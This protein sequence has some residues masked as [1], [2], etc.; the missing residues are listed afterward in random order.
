VEGPLDALKVAVAMESA[1]L[2]PIALA[3]KGLND[4]KILRIADYAESCQQV[5]LALDQ[6]VSVSERLAAQRELESGLGRQVKRIAL[7]SGYKDPGEMPL[8]EIQ[9]WLGFYC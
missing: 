9:K 4:S 5:L 1:D 7:P 2:A 3:G 8:A 6:D